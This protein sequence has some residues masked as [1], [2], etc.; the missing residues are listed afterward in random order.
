MPSRG[1]LTGYAA[2]LGESLSSKVGLL[3]R[4]LRNAHYP[5][6]SPLVRAARS[7]GRKFL[8]SNGDAFVRYGLVGGSSCG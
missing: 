4:L 1:D 5:S 3:D 8:R 6:W 7:I 2:L